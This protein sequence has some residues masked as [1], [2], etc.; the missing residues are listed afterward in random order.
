[1]KPLMFCSQSTNPYSAYLNADTEYHKFL[2][3][4]LQSML[5]VYCVRCPVPGCSNNSA[6][7]MNDLEY[8]ESLRQFIEAKVPLLS[9][10][11]ADDAE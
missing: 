6:L 1:M 3:E 5:T 2:K 10:S 4:K 9:S 11:S 8:E 7:S